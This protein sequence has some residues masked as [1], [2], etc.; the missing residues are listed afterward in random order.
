MSKDNDAVFVCETTTIKIPTICSEWSL[1]PIGDIHY[2]TSK[3][4]VD[5]FKDALHYCKNLRKKRVV[6]YVYM[7]D[8]LDIASASERK[9]LLNSDLHD[10]TYE[11]IDHAVIARGEEL[12][13]LLAFTIGDN[14][15][16]VEGNHKWV[17]QNDY[18]EHDVHKGET[19]T[20]WLARRLGTAWLGFLT[21]LRV[22]V[23]GEKSPGNDQYTYDIVACHGKGGGKLVGTSI[24]QVD[25]IRKIFP[26]ADAYCLPEQAELL[27]TAGWKRSGDVAPGDV[28]YALTGD[29]LALT[30]SPVTKVVAYQHQGDMVRVKGG[31]TNYMTTP[32]HR[33]YYRPSETYHKGQWLIKPAGVLAE[34]NSQ[35]TMPLAGYL[36]TAHDVPLSDAQLEL[37]GW[38]IAE[39]SFVRSQT[40]NAGA[41]LC[42][43]QKPGA[44]AARICA[45]ITQAGYTYHSRLDKVGTMVFY[46]PAAQGKQIRE[47]VSNKKRLPQWLYACSQRQFE[48]VFNAYVAGDGHAASGM[49]GAVYSASEL[50][51][52]DWQMALTLHGYR[53]GKSW[54]PGGFKLGGW[55]LNYCRKPTTTLS[56][57]KRMR[58]VTGWSG[59]V[60][61]VTT[62]HGNF[63]ARMNGK[64]FITG[65][66]MGHNHDRGVHPVSILYAPSGRGCALPMIKQKRQFLCRT[67]SFQ[68]GYVAGEHSYVVSRLLRPSEL[69]IIELRIQRHRQTD[70]R[71]GTST[72]ASWLEVKA[73]S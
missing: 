39:G 44:K 48:L 49:S 52:D 70:T 25:D 51:I 28:T 24:N 42:L 57:T 56:T 37:V 30:E 66:C 17:F 8:E 31:A 53:T 12:L 43:Y 32:E 18:P 45:T 54:K 61:C 36:K 60:W 72:R 10:A 3:C 38:L 20:R 5:R 67:G 55:V 58:R 26:V 21:Y 16:M 68:R 35:I 13:K 65:N 59:K 27:T 9:V 71:D 2:G 34:Y 4:D 40:N 50:L 14:L 62:E 19:S 69:G 15:G 33:V 64:V 73:I 46:I 1:V 22:S 23:V 47:Y 11:Q 6:K 63:V 41:G 29:L 7:G